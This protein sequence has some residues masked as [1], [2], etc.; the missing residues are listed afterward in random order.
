MAEDDSDSDEPLGI[1]DVDDSDEEWQPENE[2]NA[3]A[4]T[5]ATA[6]VQRRRSARNNGKRPDY[7]HERC[8]EEFSGCKGYSHFGRTRKGGDTRPNSKAV[9]PPKKTRSAARTMLNYFA[10][11]GKR[12]RPIPRVVVDLTGKQSTAGTSPQTRTRWGRPPKSSLKSEAVSSMKQRMQRT[13]TGGA[14]SVAPTPRRK[15]NGTARFNVNIYMLIY[16]ACNLY[17]LLIIIVVLIIADEAQSEE[18][19]R[20]FPDN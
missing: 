4:Q 20:Y 16:V 3:A 19:D 18:I 11:P 2:V 5:E 12:P 13:A 1:V 15:W 7:V 8:D 6:V 17:A 14:L 9:L 10:T